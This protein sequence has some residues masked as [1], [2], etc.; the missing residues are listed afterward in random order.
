MIDANCHLQFDTLWQDRVAV[1]QRAKRVGV[2][3]AVVSS[4][5]LDDGRLERLGV[6][7]KAGFSV[8]VG[9]H[10]LFQRPDDVLARLEKVFD[11]QPAW[12]LGEVGIDTRHSNAQDQMPLL[13][14]QLAIAGQ[15][16]CVLHAVGPGALDAAFQVA[17]RYPQIRGCV[18][19]FAG[20]IDQAARWVDLGWW[21]SIGGPITRPN[22]TR[23]ARWVRSVPIDS[24]LLE[25][26]APDLPP[27]NWVGVNEPAS[28]AAVCRRVAELR[29]IDP[30]LVAQT[31]TANAQRWLGLRG[32]D[33][34][35]IVL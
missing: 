34:P 5:V 25:S 11:R 1:W 30:Q 33:V 27:V 14:A 26:D 31:T 22:A 4:D 24:L 6:L 18:H 16:F 10:P 13:D 23:L 7:S 32:S 9:W 3:H 20:S 21:L 17:R 15:R 28:L 35:S 29:D 12:G 8:A 2:Q 19:A